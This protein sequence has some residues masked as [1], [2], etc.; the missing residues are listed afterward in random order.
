MKRK[1]LSLSLIIVTLCT[2]FGIVF[3]NNSN[4]TIEST[5][6]LYEKSAFEN[7]AINPE[8]VDATKGVK[9]ASIPVKIYA[10]SSFNATEISQLQQAISAWNSTKVGTVLTYA[11][12]MYNVNLVGGAIGVTKAPINPNST[13]GLTVTSVSGNTTIVKA[14]ITLNSNLTFNN[15][16]TS[17]GTYYYKSVFMHELGHALGLADNDDSSSIMCSY[18][19]GR[20]TLSTLDINDLDS[21][22]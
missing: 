22:Y 16:S 17:T 18:Y 14:L 7:G 13:I 5:H 1:I 12:T 6:Y 2:I 15:G 3:V 8:S 9:W 19:T 10:D 4:A 21:L 11:G 20:T